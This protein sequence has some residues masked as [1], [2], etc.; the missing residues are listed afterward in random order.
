[1]PALFHVEEITQPQGHSTS[2]SQER[3]KTSQRLTWENQWEC[4]K[5]MREWIIEN[6]LA[7][8]NELRDIEIAAKKFV[9]QSRLDAWEKYIAPIRKQV[10]EVISLLQSNADQQQNKDSFQKLIDELSANRE[11]LRRDVMK[12]LFMALNY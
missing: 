4:R 6:A 10:S 12:T 8:D 1:T 7:D 9:K 2:G 5:Q 11:P 3:Y